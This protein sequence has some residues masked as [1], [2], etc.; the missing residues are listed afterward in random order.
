M[1]PRK[2]LEGC[3]FEKKGPFLQDTLEGVLE[4]S[5]IWHILSNALLST[6]KCGYCFP[7]TETLWLFL[8]NGWKGCYC[9]TP[10]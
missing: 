2:Q 6:L 7:I 3:R 5:V 4:V 10:C 9:G 1:G 8:L